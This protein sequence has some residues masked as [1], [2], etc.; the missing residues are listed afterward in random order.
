MF[1]IE[2]IIRNALEEDIGLGDITTAATVAPG[3]DARAQLV[4]KEDFVLAG[5]DVAGRVFSLLDGDVAF[6]KLKEDGQQVRRGDVLAWLKGEAGSLLQGERVALNLL[7]R[8][9]GIATLT[10]RY[11]AEVEGTAAVVVDTRKTV[12]GLR[13]LDKYSVRMGGGRNHRTSLHDGVL[14]KEN[15]VAAAGGIAEAVRRARERIPHTLKIEVETRNLAEVGEA[16]EAGAEIILLDNMGPAEL[17]EAV[18]LVGGRALTE[19]S[20]G[21]RLDTVREIAETGV[22]LISVGGLTHSCRAVD[23]SMLFQ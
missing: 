14:I 10:A 8:M 13:I 9:S 23:V 22:N 12:P 4:A 7:Q 6:E 17:R 1:E 16:L 2:R 15:H 18:A 20:G 11:V 21:V 5:I 19:A 3:T